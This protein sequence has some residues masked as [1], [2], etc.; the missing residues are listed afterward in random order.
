MRAS[1][2]V[3]VAVAIWMA[4]SAGLAY[5]RDDD[6]GF[7]RAKLDDLDIVGVVHFAVGSTTL[8]AK[9]RAK[10]DALA[11]QLA[12]DTRPVEVAGHTDSSGAERTNAW[13][14][15]QRAEAVANYLVAHGVGRDRL[16]LLGYGPN[17]PMDA[18]DTDQGRAR[19]RRAEL[20]VKGVVDPHAYAPG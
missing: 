17:Q 14:S 10:L 9:A 5:A 16:T 6:S 20:K 11:A 4:G 7:E 18:N 19:N 2:A 15:T 12:Q 3:G 1:V 13:L 8:G